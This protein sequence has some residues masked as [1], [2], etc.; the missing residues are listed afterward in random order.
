MPLHKVPVVVVAVAHTTPYW[1]PLFLEQLPPI[2]YLSVAV[3]QKV[4]SIAVRPL[5][6]EEMEEIHGFAWLSQ[7]I[8]CKPM[9]VRGELLQRIRQIRIIQDVIAQMLLFLQNCK[10]NGPA[11]WEWE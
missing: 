1:F 4:V 11:M 6:M 3:V 7:I 10:E 5:L 9:E 8:L 2:L